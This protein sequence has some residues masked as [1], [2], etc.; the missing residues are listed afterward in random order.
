MEGLVLES[1]VTP[2][3]TSH[4]HSQ[5][6]NGS[7][8]SDSDSGC[9]GDDEESS[10][11]VTGSL[12][13]NGAVSSRRGIKPSW[14]TNRG[15]D[16]GFNS[17]EDEDFDSVVKNKLLLANGKE[18][19]PDLNIGFKHPQLW[20]IKG[21]INSSLCVSSQSKG[22]KKKMVPTIASPQDL[23]CRIKYFVQFSIE[24][25]MNLP[26]MSRALCRTASSLADLYNLDCAINE[27][28][29]LPVASPLLR[30]TCCTRLASDSEIEVVLRN[31]C[32]EMVNTVMSPKQAVKRTITRG[33][34][35][36]VPVSVLHSNVQRKL[37]GGNAPPIGESNI[38]N[39]LLQDM[40]WKPGSGLGRHEN[41]IQDPLF[42]EMRPKTAGLG[43]A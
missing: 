2:P 16:R 20:G 7:D 30:K 22:K 31:H 43:F 28:R 13:I 38:G 8:L 40:G 32:R 10:V 37:V 33:L 29:P 24:L 11:E 35:I 27:K 23:N 17:S 25:E 5:D 4:A 26:M 12:K 14:Y 3:I 18:W 36:H 6:N 21:G 1:H 34:P 19:L 9:E 42:A 41:G 39:R 15:A